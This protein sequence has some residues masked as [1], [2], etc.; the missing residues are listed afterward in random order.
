[1]SA[2]TFNLKQV[3]ESRFCDTFGLPQPA[4]LWASQRWAQ[5]NRQGGSNG[6]EEKHREW[7]TREKVVRPR[8]V[9][10]L[11]ARKRNDSLLGKTG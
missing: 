6:R 10:Y 5:C 1:M 2:N 3:P 9:I 7:L 4:V 11:C 8:I